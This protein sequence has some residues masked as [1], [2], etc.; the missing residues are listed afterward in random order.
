[1]FENEP[2]AV[3]QEGGNE[4]G[5]TGDA[6]VASDAGDASTAGTNGATGTTEAPAWNGELA[7]LEKE[8]WYASLDMSARDSIRSGLQAKHSS[9]EKGYRPKMEANTAKE[10]ELQTRKE[11]VDAAEK[12]FWRLQ[13]GEDDPIKPLTDAVTAAE[14][15]AAAAEAARDAA[16]AEATAKVTALEG[17]LAET[18]AA[19]STGDASGADVDAVKT[20]LAE[21]KEAVQKMTAEIESYKTAEVD[22]LTAASDAAG[23]ELCDWL[24][25][26]HPAIMADGND[27]AL[28]YYNKLIVAEIDVTEAVNL[29]YAKFP[30]LKPK[31][32]E[33]VEPAVARMTV[34]GSRPGT[35]TGEA[36]DYFAIKRRMEASNQG[37][38]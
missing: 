14:E 27:K 22:A 8:P 11:Q 35:A 4:G 10:K 2:D 3:A 28:D 24:T 12:R 1:M 18:K 33:P 23:E 38:E 30:E 7:S 5:A 6:G 36:E 16:V 20:E 32:P 29:V 19:K 9:W 25:E 21:A 15:K 31:E 17:E 34:G 37:Q 13:R 26:V